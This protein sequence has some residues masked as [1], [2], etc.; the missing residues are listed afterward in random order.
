MKI[1]FE[2]GIILFGL[3]VTVIAIGFSV[4]KVKKLKEDTKAQFTIAGLFAVFLMLIITMKLMPNIVSICD[5][6]SKTLEDGGYSIAAFLIKLVPASI[7]I[8]ILSAI[9]FYAKPIIMRR[10]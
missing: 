4:N 5:N 3:A 9:Y 6:I 2:E 1:G 7:V 10:E 8:S